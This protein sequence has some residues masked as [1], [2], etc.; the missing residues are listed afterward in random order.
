MLKQILIFSSI[1]M[2]ILFIL[3]YIF[4]RNLIYFPSKDTPDRQHYDAEDMQVIKLT[5]NDHLHLNAWYKPPII[6]KPTILYLHGNGGH[7][8]YRMYLIRYLLDQ[9]YGVL[10][11]DYRGYGGNQGRPT[12]KGFY[13]D[14]FAAIRFLQGQGIENSQLILYGESLGTGVATKLASEFS[15]C[16]LILQSAYTSLP[17]LAH[18]HYPWILISPKDQYNSLE[19]IKKIHVPILFLHGKQDEIVPYEQGRELFKHANEPKQWVEFPESGHNN[20]WDDKFENVINNF[21]EHYGTPC[22]RSK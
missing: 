19:R 4:Q 1:V 17:A 10:L 7:I 12:E 2:L 13:Q 11:P 20:M 6:G 16:A 5:T 8:G 18:Y 22:I 9:G 21:V 3:V 15:I 14:G